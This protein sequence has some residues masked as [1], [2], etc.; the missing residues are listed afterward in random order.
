WLG[1]WSSVG[2]AWPRTRP[3]ARSDPH[4][5][6]LPNR[7][8]RAVGRRREPRPC[9][10]GSPMRALVTGA[11]GFVGAAVARALC[12]AGWQVRAL[13]R[14]TSDLRNLRQHPLEL[15]IGDLHDPA[16]LAKAL[17]GCEALFHVAADYRLG[18]ADPQQLY[19]TNVEGTRN[20]LEAARG[21]GI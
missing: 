10:S 14:P 5:P 1:D 11:T 21:A 7:E 18:V 17:E 2:G 20:L 16:S 6:P 13:A 15:A 9:L 4:R 8:P 12:R 19:R 3:V